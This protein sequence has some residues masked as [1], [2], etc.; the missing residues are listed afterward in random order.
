[1]KIAHIRKQN[2][3]KLEI[4]QTASKMFIENGYSKTSLRSISKELDIS[5]GHLMFYFSS[6]EHLLSV[7]VDI[8]CDFQWKLISEE[9]KDG[10]DP[11]LAIC[12]ELMTMASAAETDEIARDFFVSAYTSPLTLEII[13]KNDYIR[14]KQVFAEF[15]PDWTDDDFKDAESLVSGIEFATLM[16]TESSAPLEK[17]ISGALDMLMKIYNVPKDIRK[18]NI[19]KVLSMDYAS[20]GSKVFQY[21][22]SYI[23][24]ENEQAFEEILK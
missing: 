10:V 21:F 16:K 20:I 12:L 18:E 19:E 23:E 22:K 13:R 11:L 4:I 24:E 1:M 5:P 7:L 15:C 6:K 3:T 8:L 17:R 2:T 14:A 9:G